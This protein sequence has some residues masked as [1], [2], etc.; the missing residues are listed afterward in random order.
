MKGLSASPTFCVLFE[1]SPQAERV[2]Y[3]ILTVLLRVLEV[4]NEMLSTSKSSFFKTGL[5][6]A[7]DSS[8]L[9][10]EKCY[11]DK[12][13]SLC[14]INGYLNLS[15]QSPKYEKSNTKIL[16]TKRK[17]FRNRSKS[18]TSPEQPN[19]GNHYQ[20]IIQRLQTL[21]TLTTLSKTLAL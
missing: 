3:L 6:E 12:Y 4:S 8:L 15:K 7:Q 2:G 16:V 5:G 19:P 17:P 9:Q 14:R 11:A 18:K 10:T 21:G 20:K 13:H 1:S